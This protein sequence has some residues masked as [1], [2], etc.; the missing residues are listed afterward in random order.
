LYLAIKLLTVS[1]R[2]TPK[3]SQNRKKVRILFCFNDITAVIYH[4]NALISSS[5]SFSGLLAQKQQLLTGPKKINQQIFLKL[6]KIK[7]I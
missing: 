5:K 6:L 7:E 1:A 2:P 4:G 3:N